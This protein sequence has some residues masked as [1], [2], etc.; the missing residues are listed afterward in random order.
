MLTEQL[1]SSVLT[2]NL[3]WLQGGK[4]LH[5]NERDLATMKFLSEMKLA[6][7]MILKDWADIKLK[8]SF[9]ERGFH[10]RLLRLEKAKVLSSAKIPGSA[11]SYYRITGRGHR[12]LRQRVIDDLPSYKK[13]VVVS[14]IHHDLTLS[15]LRCLFFKLGLCHSWTSE[16]LIRSKIPVMHSW[17]K[18]Y[19]P[20]AIYTK[21]CGRSVALELEIARKS[22]PRYETKIK[23]YLSSFKDLST[24]S[25]N[26]SSVHY[27]CAKQ[28]VQSMLE[29]KTSH[30]TQFFKVE[31]LDVYS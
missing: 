7:R 6:T 10:N 1:V 26:V 14:E 25:L 20:D 18:E 19:L 28:G 17:K 23:K 21:P 9:G 13:N 29:S 30:L 8:T 5:F 24:S 31:N 27:I 2:E 11:K 12:E 15:Y 16:N 3:D 22:G 4:E